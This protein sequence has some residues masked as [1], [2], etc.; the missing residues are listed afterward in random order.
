M[1]RNAIFTLIFC[2]VILN[3]SVWAGQKS[4]RVEIR[5]APIVD[6]VRMLTKIGGKSVVVPTHIDENVTASFPSVT[7]DAALDAVLESKGLGSFVKNGVVHISTKTDIEAMGKDLVLLTFALKYSKA[8]EVGT[9]MAKLVSTRG[10]VMIDERTNSVTVRDTRSSL[11]NVKALV[12]NIDKADRQVLIE[13]RIVQASTDFAQSLGIKWDITFGDADNHG[14]FDNSPKKTSPR[15]GGITVALKPVDWAW[16][17]LQLSAGEEKGL[18]SIISKPSIVTMNNQAATIRSGEKFFI[19]APGNVNIGTGAASSSDGEAS[20]DTQ[21]SAGSASSTNMKEVETGLTMIA[22]PQITVDGKISLL[23][24]VTQSQID[25][26][27]ARVQGVPRIFDNRATTTVLLADGE[28]TVIAGL[29]QILESDT[30]NGIP[31]LQDIPIFGRL[32]SSSSKVS[33]KSELL[34]FIKPT[35]ISRPEVAPKSLFLN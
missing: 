34:I 2:G 22:T 18:V 9:Q 8:K 25:D 29:S 12:R 3:F 14:T 35:V 32:F 28:T 26:A 19:I 10:T 30:K 5:N 7:T 16:L 23:L 13:A 27:K 20:V 15:D 11:K 4:Y 24:D 6:V 1:K 21:A 31:G 17:N 33:K